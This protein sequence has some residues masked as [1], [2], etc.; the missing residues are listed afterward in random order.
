[1]LLQWK[2]NLRWLKVLPQILNRVNIKY[3]WVK[4]KLLTPKIYV[5]K[6]NSVDFKKIRYVLFKVILKET[7]SSYFQMLLRWKTMLK[8]YI[9]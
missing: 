1:M 5:S 6:I 7:D 2:S 9:K 3:C 8:S 4:K